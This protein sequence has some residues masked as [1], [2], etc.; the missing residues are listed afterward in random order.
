V[1]IV[2]TAPDART[3][4]ASSFLPIRQPVSIIIE[5]PDGRT[6]PLVRTALYADGIL[7]DE[8]TSEPFDQFTWDLSSYTDSDQHILT[9]EA[10]DNL[11]LSKVSLGIPVLVTIVQPQLGLLPWLSRNNLWVALGGILFAGAVLIVTLILSRAKRHRSATTSPGS[12]RDLLT[13]STQAGRGKHILRLP[14]KNPAKLPGA[15]LVRLK[16]D[17]QPVTAPPIPIAMPEMTFGSDPIQAT[18]ILDDPSVSLL[19]ARLKEEHGEY[20]LSDE[21]S[22]AGTWINYEELV[23]PRRL[24]HG[25]VLHIGRISYRFM[26]RKPPEPRTPQVTP[27]KK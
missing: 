9:V 19:H 25:D 16:D 22:V 1:Q 10:L 21:K 24:Q 14:W 15:F 12:R 6:R 5:F 11:G 2:R 18:H 13:Q 8:N 27:T 20:I 4:A 23:A 3:T 17:G 26:L 7:A